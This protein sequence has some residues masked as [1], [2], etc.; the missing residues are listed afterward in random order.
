MFQPNESNLKWEYE[1]LLSIKRGFSLQQLKL[2]EAKSYPIET[3]YT[4]FMKNLLKEDRDLRV[5]SAKAKELDF[6]RDNMH[7]CRCRQK[8]KKSFRP[9]QPRFWCEREPSYFMK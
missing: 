9:C 3:A 1:A 2:D 6:P 8:T 5:D 7:R 4:K